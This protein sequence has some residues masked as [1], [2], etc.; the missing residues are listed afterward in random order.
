MFIPANNTIS[1]IG[2]FEMS[3]RKS[4]LFLGN[5]AATDPQILKEYRIVAIL[6]VAGGL[7]VKPAAKI[8]H[9]VINVEDKVF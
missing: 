8:A 6:T 4:I 5:L 2:E 3:Q 9:K 7:E 1:K